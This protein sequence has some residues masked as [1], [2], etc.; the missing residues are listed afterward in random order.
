MTLFKSFRAPLS[1][2]FFWDP[3]IVA[4]KQHPNDQQ[5]FQ[6]IRSSMIVV[7]SEIIGDHDPFDL[8]LSITE[9]FFGWAGG[10]VG[11]LLL[12]PVKIAIFE[13]NQKSAREYSISKV[14]KLLPICLNPLVARGDIGKCILFEIRPKRAKLLA[15]S[16]VHTEKKI[17]I[18]E[19][20]LSLFEKQCSDHLN[21]PSFNFSN[22][23][24]RKAKTKTVNKP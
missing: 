22:Q 12:C 6:K 5:S 17:R 15:L 8:A 20:L 10:F 21:D 11:W 9:T 16:Q 23:K 18:F 3:P 19:S 24:L 2:R 7:W 13:I 14:P 1:K 4:T